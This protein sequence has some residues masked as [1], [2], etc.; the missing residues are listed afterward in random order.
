MVI[1]IV[2]LHSDYREPTGWITRG[3]ECPGHPDSWRVS[4]DQCA[5]RN[6]NQKS[7]SSSECWVGKWGSVWVHDDIS[8]YM[9]H[10]TPSRNYLCLSN[11]CLLTLPVS[12]NHFHGTLWLYIC[13][14]PPGNILH[15][16]IFE[17]AGLQQKAGAVHELKPLSRTLHI[18]KPA[19]PN[20]HIG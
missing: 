9:I 13:Q 6:L 18:Q 16:P 4:K 12:G 7:E 5:I 15:L 17:I 19:R 10:D 14:K 11:L 8:E 2:P 1:L 3:A 20:L